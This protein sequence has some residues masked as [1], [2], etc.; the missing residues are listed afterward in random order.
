MTSSATTFPDHEIAQRLAHM[1]PQAIA[2]V[3]FRLRCRAPLDEPV[4]PPFNMADV[5]ILATHDPEVIS[6][7]AQLQT[8]GTEPLL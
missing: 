6:V 2:H 1:I 4:L 3:P 5:I 8:D 7:A